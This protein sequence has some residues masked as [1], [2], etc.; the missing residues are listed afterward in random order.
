MADLNDMLKQI[1]ERTTPDQ[2]RFVDENMAIVDYI[3]QLLDEKKMKPIDLA[4]KLEK[5]P[6]EISKWLSGT[7]NLTLQSITKIE[8][9]LDEDIIMTPVQAKSKYESIKY[10]TLKVFGH[11]NSQ[12]TSLKESNSYE[13][14][15]WSIESCSQGIRSLKSAS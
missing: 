3:H 15:K 6:A 5:T 7:H 11:V 1:R 10:V 9:A 14:F 12:D 13:D 4:R 8:A 2:E